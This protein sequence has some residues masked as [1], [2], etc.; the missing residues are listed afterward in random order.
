MGYLNK[1]YR[2]AEIN[3]I[4]SNHEGF[5]KT[6]WEAMA[7]SLPVLATS[8]GG[9]PDYLTNYDNAIFVEPKNIMSC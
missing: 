7:N 2:K 4:P 8:E 6:I 1:M 3:A 5:V 9:I